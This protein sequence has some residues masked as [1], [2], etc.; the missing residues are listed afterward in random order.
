M[1]F[2]YL[3]YCNRLRWTLFTK[4]ISDNYTFLS[5]ICTK[6]SLC[7]I[8][9]NP[10]SQ[11]ACLIIFDLPGEFLHFKPSDEGEQKRT[12]NTLYSSVSL[13]IHEY[14][15]SCCES[16]EQ[17]LGMWHLKTLQSNFNDF[18]HLTIYLL[19]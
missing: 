2:F 7:G 5:V 13:K 11:S 1:V 19:V 4:I 17:I 10:F 6:T 9:Q 12:T 8:Y 16:R 18:I 14:L 3:L 15:V